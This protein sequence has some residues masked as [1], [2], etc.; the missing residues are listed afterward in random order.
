MAVSLAIL[1]GDDFDP[2]IDTT[3]WENITGVANTTFVGSDG[4]SL[5]FDNNVREAISIPLDLT[6]AEVV[7]FDLIIS[8]GSNG[9]ENAD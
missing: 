4:N 8:N 2:N 5:F 3:Q 9:G 1:F 7:K 6:V